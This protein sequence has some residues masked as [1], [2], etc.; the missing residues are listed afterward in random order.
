MNLAL[1]SVPCHLFHVSCHQFDVSWHYFDSNC[2]NFVFRAETR[3]AR[4][5]QLRYGHVGC[6]AIG[7]TYL[8]TI[9]SLRVVHDCTLPSSNGTW[10]YLCPNLLGSSRT[11]TRSQL[12]SGMGF[13]CDF[14]RTYRTARLLKSNSSLN[15][16]KWPVKNVISIEILKITQNI[17][18]WEKMFSWKSKSHQK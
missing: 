6:S 18:N 2:H 15:K 12:S 1:F 3:F 13:T 7:F 5:W 9:V 8:L 11:K 16:Q 10:G 14:I 17:T 4:K